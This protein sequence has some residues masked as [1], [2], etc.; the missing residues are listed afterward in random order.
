MPRVRAIALGALL[1]PAQARGLRRLGQ[2]HPRADPTQLLDHEP[3]AGRRLQRDFQLLA[4]EALEKAPA[5]SSAKNATCSLPRTGCP[6]AS[7]QKNGRPSVPKPAAWPLG[8]A[9]S[10]MPNAARAFS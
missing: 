5:R 7:I 4:A 1:R 10:V 3:P 6:C 8:S 2:M 9:R